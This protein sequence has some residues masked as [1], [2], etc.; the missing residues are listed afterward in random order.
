MKRVE[1]FLKFSSFLFYLVFSSNAFA[2]GV[3]STKDFLAIGVHQLAA[4]KEAR[5][6]TLDNGEN[7]E[8][9]KPGLTQI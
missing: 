3:G 2:L 6:D 5:F 8:N 4:Q 9:V 7:Y 1:I